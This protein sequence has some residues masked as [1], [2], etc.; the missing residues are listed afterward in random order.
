MQDTQTFL[1]NFNRY[2]FR[3]TPRVL[4]IA[5]ERISKIKYVFTKPE[6]ISELMCKL[7]EDVRNIRVE[8]AVYIN[9]PSWNRS[10]FFDNDEE[11]SILYKEYLEKS[12]DAITPIL[13][14]KEPEYSLSMGYE[15]L[16][17]I[18]ET[19]SD[20]VTMSSAKNLLPIPSEYEVTSDDESECDVPVKDESSLVFTIF[21]NP[22]FDDNDDFTSSDDE[23]LPEEDVLMEDFKVY[24]DPLFNDDEINSDELDPHCFN[25]EYDFIESLSNRDTLIDSSP[26]FDYLEEFSGA[27]MP[28]SIA[29][30]ERI[31]RE[32]AKYISLM[33][34]L[35]TINPFPCPLENFQSNTIIETLPTSPIPLEDSDSQRE[36]IDIFTDTD[37]LLP[38]SIESDDYDSE[39]DI[40]FLEEL[41]IDDSIPIPKNE[42]SDFDHQDDPSYPRPPPKPPDVEIFFKP[43][44]GV[45]TTNVVKGISEHYVLM[46]KNF[47]TLPTFDPIYPVYDTLLP[48]SSKNKDKCSNL[49][50]RIENKAKTLALGVTLESLSKSLPTIVDRWS[51]GVNGRRLPP[52][53]TGHH[54]GPPPLIGGPPPLTGVRRRCG[55]TNGRMTRHPRYCKR[56]STRVQ[57]KVQKTNGQSERTIQTL[58]DMLRACVI[59]FGKRWDTRLPLEARDRQKSYTDRRRKLLE[60]QSGDKVMLK[61]LPWKGVIRFG[62]REKLNPRYIGPFK[63]LAKAGTVAYRLELS[64]QLSRVHRTFHFSNLNKCF[65][66]EPLAI[67]LDEFHIDDQ[68]NFIKEPVEIMD[69]EVKRLKQIRI[70]IVKS[71][72]TQDEVLSLLGSAR[73]K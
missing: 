23:S 37:D 51:G 26:K 62:K 40:Y 70:P 27:F 7:L 36:E 46:P 11:D 68:V 34:T 3:V 66:D 49:V 57:Y 21:S 59:D 19:E 42:S 58:E 8:L 47:P 15:H 73:T 29:D 5:W 50:K 20:E 64:D 53:T 52:L 72:G 9:S 25:V 55:W 17:T 43:D 65:S 35:F 60:F 38:P 2:S 31:R 1:E 18:L 13:P 24:S 10:T 16:S 71:V 67:Q 30:E 44:L 45:L 48:F 33:E 54:R 14:T 61:V 22:L 41:L 6:E 69:R 12:Y 39:G 56:F 63:I 32:H 4:S 28:T